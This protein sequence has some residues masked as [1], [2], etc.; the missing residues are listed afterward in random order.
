MQANSCFPRL[1]IAC[2]VQGIEHEE[3]KAFRMTI[4]LNFTIQIQTSLLLKCIDIRLAMHLTC[5]Q[6]KSAI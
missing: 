3:W 2:E 1:Y 6:L 4:S 5:V